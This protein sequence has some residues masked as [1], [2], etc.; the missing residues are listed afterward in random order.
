MKSMK[1]RRAPRRQAQNAAVLAAALGMA[2]AANASA[3]GID[4][5]NWG[6][7]TAPVYNLFNTGSAVP[8]YQGAE[9]FAGPNQFGSYYAGVAPDGKILKPA[10]TTIQI[11]MDPLGVA[12]TP[13]GKFLIAANSDEREGNFVSL[14]SAINKGGYSLSVVN[15]ATMQVVSQINNLPTYIGLQITSNADGS[16]TVWASGGPNQTAGAP[17]VIRIFTVSTAGLI[18]V[19]ATGATINISP[20][21]PGAAGYISNYDVAATTKG[22]AANFAGDTPS[23][24]STVGAKITFPA[25]SALDP[26]GRYLYV[27]CNG[28]NSLAIIDTT[29]KTVVKQL[30]VGYFPYA[31]SISA[32]G[33]KVFV[34]NWGMEEY[35]FASPAYNAAGRLTAIGATSNSNPLTLG[36]APAGTS[37]QPDGFYVPVTNTSGSNPKTS[38]V[39]IVSVTGG[40]PATAAVLGS[41]YEGKPLDALNQ[42]GDTHPS[43]TAIVKRGAA[44]VLYVAKANDN[45]LGMI[46]LSNNRRLADFDLSPISVSLPGNQRIVGAYPNAL[47]AS[48]DG[49]RLYVA[50]AGTN[51]VAVLDTTSPAAP[52]V[53][54]R[55]GTDWY[56]TA[57]TLSADGKTLYVA[58]AKGV[59]EDINPNTNNGATANANPT[60]T[61][62]ESYTDSNF[63]FGSLQKIDLTQPVPT[64]AA[65]LANVYARQ[66]LAAIDASVVPAGIPAGVTPGSAAAGSSKIKH[67]IFIIHEN[68]TFDSML[69]N[70]SNHFGAFA[71]TQFNNFS[72]TGNINTYDPNINVNT[73][74]G[75]GGATRNNAN[76]GANPANGTT[77]S[78]AQYTPVD[79]N[80]QALALSFA[81]AVNYYSNSEE[82]DAGHQFAASG[83][84]SDYTQKTLLVKTGRGM[85]ANKNF[86]PEDYPAGGYIFNNAARNGVSFK[87]YGAMVRIQGTDTGANFVNTPNNA[88]LNDPSSGKDGYP[89]LSG[90]TPNNGTGGTTANT[91]VNVVG[92]DVTSATSGLGQ[93]YYQALPILAILGGTN[94]SGEA[95]LDPNYPGY[96]FSI[97][98]QRRALEFIRDYDRMLKAGTLPQFLYIYQPNDHTGT[99]YVATAPPAPTGAQEVADG[100]VGLGMVISHIMSSPAYYNAADGTGSAIFITYDD[101]QSTLDH[102]HQHRTPLIV[103]SPYAKTQG[104]NQGFV[105][106][107]HYVTASIVKTEE[108]LLG[109]PPLNYGDLTATDLRDMF[110]PTYNGITA[111]Q[112]TFNKAVTYVATAEGKKV[113][114]LAKS[115]DSSGPDKD[116]RRLGALS[117][118]SMAADTLHK[119]AARKHTLNTAAYKKAQAALYARAEMVVKSPNTGKDD[120]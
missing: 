82:S 44:A 91:V 78:D 11:G 2:L 54:G 25:G 96:N 79:F 9:L 48:A 99:P 52:K 69:G 114:A 39:T 102:I 12:L 83:T 17:G 68:K 22:D 73:P 98:D 87:D 112:I 86:E 40:S 113:W 43:A 16:Y 116:S 72:A 57:L 10:G 3:Q 89:N 63:I 92:S 111:S 41:I 107:R 88:L 4:A 15:T 65:A 85:F 95:H 1:K 26:T 14:Q 66:P 93:S 110:Q 64:S 71:S 117:R 56:P 67:V 45:S 36:G 74:N 90:T 101:A 51:T 34:S 120:D 59:G 119:T 29:T 76:A 100:D 49:T 53:I 38:S 24:F 115:L 47:V 6:T 7:V 20:I 5:T 30:S 23:Q 62:I 104:V 80:T 31:V 105:A 21:Q 84:S 103:V 35:K 109:L 108:L 75:G 58:N 19:P 94:A 8:A 32:D 61:G 18:S 27:A 13:D 33:T 42:V 37:N 60:A 50:E 81:T 118:I 77:Y 46:L 28:D 55:F 70:Q 106:T 97:S